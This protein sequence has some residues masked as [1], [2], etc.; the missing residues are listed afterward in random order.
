MT[1]PMLTPTVKRSGRAAAALAAVEIWWLCGLAAGAGDLPNIF[2]IVCEDINP[3]LGCYGDRYARTPNLDRFASQA[4]RYASCWSSAPVCAPARTTLISGVYPTCTGAEHMRSEV[5]MPSWMRMYPQLLREQGYHCSNRSKED[6]NLTKPGRIWDESSRTAHWR[7]RQPGQP[8]FAVC[9]LEV[10]HESQIRTRPHTL[11]HD[12]AQARLPAYHPDTPEVRHDWAQYHDQISRMDALFQGLLEEMEQAGLK[13]DTIVFFYGDNGSGMPRS[14]RWPYNSGLHVPLIV[15]VPEKFKS[16]APP[17]YAP[18]A[19]TSRLIGFIDFAPT[20]LSIAGLKPPA[21]MQGH[22]FMGRFTEPPPSW[23][24]GFRGRMDERYDLVRSVRNQR[25]SYVRNYMPHLIYGQHIDYMFQTPTT[26]VWKQLYDQGKLEPPRTRFW[27]TKPPEE[28]YD[29]QTDPDEVRNLVH[30][31]E[32]RAVLEELRQAQREQVLRTRDLGFLSEAEQHSRSTGTTPYEL[33]HDPK[34]YPLEKILAMAELASL[35]KPEALP[36]LRAG[37]TDSESAVRYWAAMGLLMR[38]SAA[39]EATRVDLRAALADA[40]PTVRV[41]AA[42]ALG[43]YG[44]EADLALALPVLRELAPPDRNGA[45]IALLALNALEALGG[46]AAPLMD[47]IKAL[48][49]KDPAAVERANSY[50]ARLVE[51]MTGQDQ[52]EAAASATPK[53]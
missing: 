34:K 12:P 44:A 42:Q 1:L 5:P 35:L 25:Y 6:Y 36:Q 3:N 11:Q 22:A 53:P 7:H 50:V 16:L 27:E 33:G 24:H 47:T 15:R 2:W 40:A 46:K 19:A 31:P 14:K 41:M 23:L 49:T 37:L 30:S 4:L 13:D 32:H 29:L 17:G 21:W 52:R 18:G 9:N 10:T 28:L 45:Y 20:L 8:F 43:Q 48:P 39:V 38:G 26:R 51:H